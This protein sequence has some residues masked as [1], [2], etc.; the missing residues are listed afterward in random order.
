MAGAAPGAIMDEDYFG[1][2]AEWGDEAEGG[3]VRGGTGHPR[4]GMLVPDAGWPPLPPPRDP[5]TARPAP[6]RRALRPCLEP[7]PLVAAT[8]THRAASGGGGVG[9]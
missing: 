3:Q 9:R 7:A 5:S 8:G 6:S 2:A 1:N 4:R